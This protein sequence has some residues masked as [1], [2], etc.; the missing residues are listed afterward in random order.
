VLEVNRCPSSQIDRGTVRVLEAYR[1]AGEGVL[2]NPGGLWDQP[3]ELIRAFGL[4]DRER[5]RIDEDRRKRQ[6]DFDKR[7]RGR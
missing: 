1:W 2:P 7:N 6:K 3:A 5:S 4:I